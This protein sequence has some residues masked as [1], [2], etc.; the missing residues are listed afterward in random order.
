MPMG[1]STMQPTMDPNMAFNPNMQ[2][3]MNTQFAQMQMQANQT[4]QQPNF[5]SMMPQTTGM[6]MPQNRQ[7]FNPNMGMPQQMNPNM[8]QNSV[9]QSKSF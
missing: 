6:T 4:A 7:Q 5:Q 3:Q 1:G 9:N 8:A 2:P